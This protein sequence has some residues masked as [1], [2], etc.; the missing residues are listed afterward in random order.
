MALH[1]FDKIIAFLTVML[2]PYFSL[3]MDTVSVFLYD[4]ATQINF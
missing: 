1:G 2:F 4:K 3:S